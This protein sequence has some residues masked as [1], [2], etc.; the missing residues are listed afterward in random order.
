[1]LK[2]NVGAGRNRKSGYVGVDIVKGK[3]VDK[4]AP[5]WDMP[6][7]DKS[8]DEIYTHHIIEHIGIHDLDKTLKE[9]AR[10]LKKGGKLII[11]CPDFEKHL[12]RWLDG[13]AKYRWGFG[14]K[15]LLGYQTHEGQFH[16]NGFTI[17]R[18]KHLLPSYGF[19]IIEIRN[20]QNKYR[21]DREFV[22]NGDIYVEAIKK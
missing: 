16:K 19:N 12:K 13:D 6:F 20:Q 3:G 2:L 17:K 22:P 4:I 9:F 11:I 5:A 15:M 21:R 7:D 8:V 10:V 1:M 14:L 18:F